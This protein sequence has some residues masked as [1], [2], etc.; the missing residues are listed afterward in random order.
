MD[1]AAGRLDDRD[2]SA[3]TVQLEERILKRFTDLKA[4]LDQEKNDDAQQAPPNEQQQGDQ[5]QSGPDGEMVP[6]IAQLKVI[7][8]PQADLIDRVTARDREA[9]AGQL[10]DNDLG[11][12]RRRS[13]AAIPACRPRP[14]K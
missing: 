12:T 3:D 4:A 13:H 8:S 6:I 2:T 9:A 5:N 11:R 7:R 1:R 10:S 14:R